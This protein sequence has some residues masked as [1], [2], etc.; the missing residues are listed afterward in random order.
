[1]HWYELFDREHEPSETQIRE[2]I[3]TSLFDD[4][5]AYLRHTYKVK[6]RMAYSNCGMDKGLW[7]G[8]NIKYQKG[9]KSLCTLYPKQGYLHLLLPVGMRDMDEAEVMIQSCTAYT[10]DL[11]NHTV[12]GHNGKSLAFE[13]N[14]E[15]VLEDMKIM[16][17]LRVSSS[18]P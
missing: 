8:W 13:V 6:P 12:C 11:F 3:D 2:Y 1:M 17:G 14:D 9:G 10:Q 7:R 16:I 18:R 5:D 15:A 4:L